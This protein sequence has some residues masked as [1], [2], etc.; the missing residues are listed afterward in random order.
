MRHA[1]HDFCDAFFFQNFSGFARFSARFGVCGS[2][3]LCWTYCWNFLTIR[4]PT[5]SLYQYQPAEP[6][7]RR[8]SSPRTLGGAA[9]LH[10]AT[11]LLPRTTLK[12]Q[13]MNHDINKKYRPGGKNRRPTYRQYRFRRFMERHNTALTLALLVGTIIAFYSL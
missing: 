6:C 13:K 1:Y 3:V 11:L 8:G 10:P 2:F 7:P 5:D 12:N 4:P 9:P